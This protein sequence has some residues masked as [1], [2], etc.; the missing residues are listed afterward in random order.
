MLSEQTNTNMMAYWRNV[1]ISQ[2]QVRS[3]TDEWSAL[4]M[5][6]NHSSPVVCEGVLSADRLVGSFGQL[7]LTS[8]HKC[9]E[10]L[11]K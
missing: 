9:S 2:D 1:F 3:S 8:R 7:E 4:G 10:T 6:G 5:R 11:T